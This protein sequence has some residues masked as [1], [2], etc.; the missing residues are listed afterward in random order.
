MWPS[1]SCQE[2]ESVCGRTGV[3]IHSPTPEIGSHGGRSPRGPLGVTVCQYPHT[4][5]LGIVVLTA[6]IYYSK[7]IQS[8]TNTERRCT[9]HSLGK[10]GTSLQERPSLRSHRHVLNSCVQ[11][12]QPGKLRASVPGG[13]SWGLFV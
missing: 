1:E 9:V 2:P 11:C 13:F 7:R 3:R 10:P 12:R 4:W 5:D 6:M 8:N